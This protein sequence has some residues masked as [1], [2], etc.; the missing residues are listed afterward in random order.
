[1]NQS[2]RAAREAGT[3]SSLIRKSVHTVFKGGPVRYRPR[4]S[5]L[6]PAVNF[7][8]SSARV[9]VSLTL[10]LIVAAGCGDDEVLKPR[11]QSISAPS[12]PVGPTSGLPGDLDSYTTGGAVSSAH[13]TLEYRFDFDAAGSHGYSPWS[14]TATAN[15]EWYSTGTFVVRAQ[16][17][18]AA[19]PSVVS[20]WSG[21]LTVTISP[22]ETVTAPSAPSGAAVVTRG[23]GAIYTSGGA[24]SSKGHPIEYR[25]HVY[26]VNG[27]V[28]EVFSDWSSSASFNRTWDV[29]GTYSVLAEAR[30]G[31]DTQITAV[32]QP[33]TVTVNPTG[34]PVIVS[35]HLQLVSND[36]SEVPLVLRQALDAWDG[37]T[38][39]W[40]TMPALSDSL[41]PPSYTTDCPFEECFNVVRFP[42]GTALLQSWFDH[43]AA[44]DGL[45]VGPGALASSDITFVDNTSSLST[46]F[47][48]IDW[49]YSDETVQRTKIIPMAQNTYVDQARPGLNFASEANLVA[50]RSGGSD[51]VILL[52][53]DVILP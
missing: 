23:D 11:P 35:G 7:V 40:G 43:T 25:F 13:D 17:R 51:Q 26:E 16:A 39:T 15:T 19:H 32:S 46:P 45:A 20:A 37:Q 36:L 44:N 12:T 5:C 34:T 28:T 21:G 1:M 27:I 47:L 3:F 52:K 24:T 30:C 6:A 10:A 22:V 50:G 18:S 49:R 2:F 48:W 4:T 9:P 31:T 42:V 29:A 33:L 14:R 41:A 38:V 53:A 8:K